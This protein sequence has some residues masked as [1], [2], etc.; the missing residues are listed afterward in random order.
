MRDDVAFKFYGDTFSQSLCPTQ[1]EVAVFLPL[2]KAILGDSFPFFLRLS[3][4]YLH[5]NLQKKIGFGHELSKMI[6]K[7]YMVRGTN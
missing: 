1:N 2:F 5:K 3:V 6:R 4:S 7:N